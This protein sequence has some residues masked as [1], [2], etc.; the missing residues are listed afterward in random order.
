[1]YTTIEVAENSP[2]SDYWAETTAKNSSAD[3]RFGPSVSARPPM[4]ALFF[5]R[6]DPLVLLSARKTSAAHSPEPAPSE[7]KTK[8]GEKRNE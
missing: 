1:M 4:G 5:I 7:K 3:T 6:K 8:S 2:S